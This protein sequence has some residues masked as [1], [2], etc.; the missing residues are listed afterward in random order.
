MNVPNFQLLVNVD[1]DKFT[2]HL[3]CKQRRIDIHLLT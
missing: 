3:P 2:L 1:S